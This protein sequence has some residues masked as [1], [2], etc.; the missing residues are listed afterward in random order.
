[1]PQLNPSPW[2]MIL[3]TSWL[4]FLVFMPLKVLSHSF[5]PQLS[6]QTRKDPVSKHWAWPW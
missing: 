4:V 5:N 1:M 3:L 2:F 6:P